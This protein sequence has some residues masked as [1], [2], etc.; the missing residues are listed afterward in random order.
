[1]LDHFDIIAPIYDKFLD[2]SDH[3]T[4][5][6]LLQPP[7]RGKLLDAGG[8]TGRVSS[9][10][11]ASGMKI[12]ISDLSLK[13]LARSHQK[14]DLIP[15]TA[16]VERLPFADN[17]FD[18]IIV[19]DALHHFCDQQEALMDLTRVLKTG[20]RMVI[21]EPDIRRLPA[22]LIALAEKLLL[23]RSHFL[24]PPDIQKILSSNGIRA[25]IE[26]ENGFASWVV[27]DK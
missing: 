26:D 12:I 22:K 4:L 20:G 9:K 14:S 16:H 18:R 13:M 10:L 27:V 5:F 6:K 24:S 25:E 15:V 21:E 1:M 23:M 3:G 7:P 17:S 8:G 19:V 2:H 11:R